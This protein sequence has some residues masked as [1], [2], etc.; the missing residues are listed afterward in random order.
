MRDHNF[1]VNGL[2]PDIASSN[3]Q[4][5]NGNCNSASELVTGISVVT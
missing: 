2:F 1:T 5:T 3:D 4:S